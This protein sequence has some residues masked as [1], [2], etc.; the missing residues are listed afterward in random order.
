[1]W[2]T[3]KK[4]NPMKTI[5]AIILS[6]LLS[7]NFITAQDTLYVYKAGNLIYKSEL[8]KVDS[9]GFVHINHSPVATN[10]NAT[11]MQNSAI[12]IS[13]LANDYDSDEDSISIIG[14]T[15]PANGTANLNT[16]GTI[17]YTPSPGF[18]GNDSFTYTISD[19]DG[20]VAIG[21]VYLM[22]S[23]YLSYA[24][25][26]PRLYY[27]VGLGDG[28]WTNSVLG[29]GKSLIPLN[30]VSGNKYNNSGDG[31]FS[32]T[33]YFNASR[34]FKLIRDLGSW[35]ESWGMTGNEYVHNAGNNITV[36]VDGYYTINL[37]SINNTLT[38]VP[39]SIIPTNYTSIG[40]T[41][42]FNSWSTDITLTPTE[43]S[44]NHI[45]YGTFSSDSGTGGCKFRANGSWTFNW[46]SVNFPY[47]ISSQNGANILYQAGNYTVI[48]N[49]IDGTFYFIKQ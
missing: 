7:L 40:L 28:N 47:G 48:F 17:T 43:T 45:W 29:L 34:P 14:I 16:N 5:C 10:D 11:L 6:L 8:S 39:N 49:D 31:E 44:N 33:G 38:I 21:T 27:I 15:N 37:N 35:S 26:T 12:T 30:I 25:V 22:V 23:G 1:M 32:Y 36:P 18:T 24:V 4:N 3:N 13:V 9:L 41:G 46:G 42:D 19:G 2:V 20:G